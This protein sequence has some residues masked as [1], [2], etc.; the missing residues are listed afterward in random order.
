MACRTL[1]SRLSMSLACFAIALLVTSL[2][3]ATSVV[4]QRDA[5]PAAARAVYIDGEGVV[6]WRDDRSEVALF[7]ANYVL[8]SASDYRAAGYLDADRKRMIEEDM[9]HFARMGWTLC[10]SPSGV[11]GKPRTARAT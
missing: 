6:R 5:P 11:T 4:A 1:P 7:G 8:P 10:G 3:S 2:A 9:A